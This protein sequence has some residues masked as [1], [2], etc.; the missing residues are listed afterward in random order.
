M[1]DPQTL[2]EFDE[3]V[4]ATATA[5]IDAITADLLVRGAWLESRARLDPD[6]GRELTV[7]IRWWDDL[8]A[9]ID[10]IAGGA[11]VAET[12][13]TLAE[14]RELNRWAHDDLLAGLQR[15]GDE[16]DRLAPDHATAAT[17]ADRTAIDTQL[18]VLELQQRRVLRSIQE[19]G[20]VRATLDAEAAKANERL[21]SW[22]STLAAATTARD[23]HTAAET[24]RAAL[25][26]TAS[27]STVDVLA[28]AAA[29]GA[30]VSAVEDELDTL[31]AGARTL[32]DHARDRLVAA[33]AE[34]RSARDRAASL[35]GLATTVAAEDANLT[36]DVAQRRV[37]FDA[38]VAA[39][40]HTALYASAELADSTKAIVDFRHLLEAD[41]PLT[42]DQRT[43]IRRAATVAAATTAS[44]AEQER[45]A[46]LAAL[47]AA[48]DSYEDDVLALLT[49]NPDADPAS[50]DRA[51]LDAARAELLATQ[52]AYS[53]V[54]QKGSLDR[55]EQAVPTTFWRSFQSYATARDTLTQLAATAPADT[56]TE[57]LDAETA[58]VAALTAAERHGRSVAIA[59]RASSV[60]AARWQALSGLGSG[61][62]LARMR[63]DD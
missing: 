18:D 26:A 40:Q 36:A 54:T 7:A 52:D 9:V 50:I 32:L 17:P 24:E 27:S 20:I 8:A 56:A 2:V 30:D 59:H 62:M 63:G 4:I 49:A 43:A 19:L 12:P 44:T 1:A 22:R 34:A 13:T 37:A 48:T 14:R 58:L 6:G 38:A 42:N 11:T 61:S 29:G 51:P 53:V 16:R 21:G 55:W 33:R 28:D 41:Q 39:L 23:D 46:A 5:G 57:A 3:H 15:I 45:D 25:I 10:P 60:A 35:A 47:R 31:F